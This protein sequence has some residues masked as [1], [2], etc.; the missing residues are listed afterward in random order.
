MQQKKII[1]FV[2]VLF[3]SS[4]LWLFRASEKAI[5]PDAGRNWWAIYFVEPKTN[6]LSFIIENHSDKSDFTWII[7][8]NN[9]KIEEGS[10]EIERGAKLEITSDFSLDSKKII[11]QV[12][13]EGEKK[14]IYKNL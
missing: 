4:S 9:Q 5:D 11:I 3:L 10:E 6:S 12:N 8:E 1:V 13:L 14:E 2:I 7:L